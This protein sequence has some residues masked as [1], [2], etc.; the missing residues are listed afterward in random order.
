[1]TAGW[2]LGLTTNS[3]PASMVACAWSA[4][5]T[6]PEPRRSFAPYSLFQLPEHIKCAGDGHGDFDDGEAAGLHGLNNG[7]SLAGI[8]GTQ[9]GNEA[10][11]FEDL[12]GGFG[13][14]I[15]PSELG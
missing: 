6:V 3:A 9:D 4:V 11:T 12:R 5:V 8:A 7:V 2:R 10:D 14:G 15:T 1:M 13:H